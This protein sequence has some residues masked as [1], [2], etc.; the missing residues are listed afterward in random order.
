MKF[1]LD[2]EVIKKL[3]TIFKNYNIQKVII[4]GSR[5]KGNYKK[6]SDIDL[7][8]IGNIDFNTKLEILEKID[9]LLLPYEVDLIDFN[10]IKNLELKNHIKRVGKEIFPSL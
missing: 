6:Y 7:A 5:A 8:F 10:K 9:D 2:E 4:F 3:N 1:G